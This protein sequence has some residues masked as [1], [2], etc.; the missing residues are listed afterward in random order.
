MSGTEAV[1]RGKQLYRMKRK[2]IIKY[3][4]SHIYSIKIFQK[5]MTQMY[6]YVVNGFCHSS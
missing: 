3:S 5:E 4:V 2:K 1:C 6:S